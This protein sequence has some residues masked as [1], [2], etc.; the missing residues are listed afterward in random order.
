MKDINGIPIEE[1]KGPT[2]S[3]NLHDKDGDVYSKGIFLHYGHTII[4][5]ATSLRGFK[6]HANH[7]ASMIWEIEEN[8]TSSEA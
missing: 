2:F 1:Y 6:A 4:K 8:I 3:I 7:L 5:V